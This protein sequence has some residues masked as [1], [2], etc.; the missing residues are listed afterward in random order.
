MTKTDFTTTLL[1]NQ[2]PKEVF[3]AL[4]N[5][6]GWWFGLYSE[7]FEG[8]SDKLGDEFSFFAGDGMHYTKQ[9]LVELIPDQKIT[10]LVTDSKLTFVQNQTEWT[11]TKLCFEIFAE[12]DA[13]KI[14]FTH[15]GLVPEFECYDSCAPA[16]TQYMQEQLVNWIT[17]ST[18]SKIVPA[19]K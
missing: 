17:T 1:V 4:K 10:W 9:K 19:G 15:V 14:K 12:G 2:S 5:V 3:D 11:G 7:K 6:R 13:T 18:A 8:E 16:W